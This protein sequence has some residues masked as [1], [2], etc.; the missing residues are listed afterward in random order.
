[1]K[2]IKFVIITGCST[3]IGYAT[4]RYLKEKKY[5]VIASCRK[6]KDVNKLSKEFD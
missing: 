1:M 3:G 4:A 5:K 2:K 6:N